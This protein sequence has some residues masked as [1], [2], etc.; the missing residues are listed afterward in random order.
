MPNFHWRV[1]LIL[2]FVNLADVS[3]RPLTKSRP[4]A[5]FFTRLLNVIGGYKFPNFYSVTDKNFIAK[6]GHDLKLKVYTPYKTD[7]PLPVWLY[8]HGG[9]FAFGAYDARSNFCKTIAT[10]A[11]CIVVSIQYRLAPE[12]PFPAAINDVYEA[13]LWVSEH[14]HEF[15]GDATKMAVGGESAGGNL[16]AA[17]SQMARD[18]GRPKII[19][20]TLL[21][22]A[23]DATL[24]Y[25]SI[26]ECATGYMLTKSL[27]QKFH[28]AYVPNEADHKNP[29]C[30]PI[31]GELKGLPPATVI[32]A[33]FD[34]LRDE[35]NM[36]AEKLKAA[37]VPVAH[38][39]FKNTIH[40][41]TMMATKHLPEARESLQ[42]IVE[43]I[44]KA[45]AKNI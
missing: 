11:D 27:M 4:V 26:D 32:T 30:S 23:V 40:D 15:G 10:R 29:Y 2:F 25:P 43:E 7:K 37:E 3:K 16:S 24:N 5:N 44:K 6:E 42:M 39:E 36:Y 45:F 17:L 19:H 18:K 41:F 1:R 8:I 38:K 13:A 14:A 22:P 28:A 31:Y 34:P 35:G 20:Q 9:G 12:N 33:E 21:Y